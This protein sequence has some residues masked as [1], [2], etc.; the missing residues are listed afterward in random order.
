VSQ[1]GTVAELT[2]N[3]RQ[4]EPWERQAL[5]D[6]RSGHVPAAVAAYRAH[7]R[8][9]IAE[10]PA[11]M[12]A[13]A[14]GRWIDAHQA[15]QVPVLLA[16]TNTIVDALNRSV[17]HALAERGLLTGDVVARFGGREF[18]AGDRVVLR[19]NSYTQLD[20]AGTEAAV[21]NAR[22]GP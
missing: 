1:A 17:R 22:P 19:R 14:T 2:V 4:H 13:D 10:D 20:V 6:L 11:A 21:L 16:G 3:R 9:V 12:L 18:I 15:G 7:G 5:D 8:V